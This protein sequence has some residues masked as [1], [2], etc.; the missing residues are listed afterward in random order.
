YRRSLPYAA[1]ALLLVSVAALAWFTMHAPQAGRD[2]RAVAMERES[3]TYF[4]VERDFGALA[5]DVRGGSAAR[6]GLA[7]GYALV[8]RA[9]GGRDYVRIDAERALVGEVLKGRLEGQ[10]P[11]VFALNGV[12]P[13]ASPV[14]SALRRLN[15]PSLRSLGCTALVL[16]CL[17][18]LVSPM[19]RSAGFAVAQRPA[20]RFSDVVGAEE[21]K[22]ALQDIV[23]YLRDPA[24]FTGLG[25]R[26]PRG[27]VLEGHFGTGKT[28][29]AR[30]VAGEAGVPFIALAGSDFSDMF[31]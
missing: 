29:L 14:A 26:P 10:S 21:A 19:M 22:E 8:E 18:W 20:T 5:Q 3:A 4:A 27:V 24:R 15:T 12:H 7:A 13:P 1:A 17:I 11:A 30:A 25:A 23:A 9:D 16:G 6:I 31:L 2:A 28:L